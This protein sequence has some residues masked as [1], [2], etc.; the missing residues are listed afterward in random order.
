MRR[1]RSLVGFLAT[2]A[3]CLKFAGTARAEDTRLI[4]EG[5][6]EASL[7]DVWSAMT[8]KG[9]LES[10]MVALADIDLKVGGKML[11]RYEADGRLGDAKTIENTIIS[12]EPKRMLSIQATKPPERFPFKEAIKEMWTVINFDPLGPKRT[13]VTVISLGFNE[14]EESRK[15]REHFRTGNEWTLKKLQGKFAPGPKNGGANPPAAA[16][17]ATAPPAPLAQELGPIELEVV[18][19]AA[20]AEVWKAWT[21]NEGAQSF[22][23]PKTNIEL[24]PGGAYEILFMPEKPKGERGAEDLKVL[25]YLPLEM[26]SF[27]WNA[28]PKFTRARPQ[29]TWLVLRFDDA[30]PERTRLRLA[31]TGFAERADAKSDERDEWVQVRAY[32]A[33]TWPY[34]LGKLHKRFPEGSN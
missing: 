11:T 22:F 17:A 33:T 26:L 20:R 16:A 19:P 23:A 28:P 25:S 1:N 27:E 14:T 4:T 30:G 24:R 9:G 6:V 5:I 2:C 8:T 12:F 10:W 15:M 34:V 3:L 29:R 18:V 13:R 32:F 31:H 21:T 7:D